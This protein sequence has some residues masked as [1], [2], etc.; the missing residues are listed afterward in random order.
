[1]GNRQNKGEIIIYKDDNTP[2]IKVNL[3]DNTVWLTQAQMA[4]LFDR[5]SDTIGEHIQNVYKTSE[6]SQNRTTGK[7]PVVQKE[8]NRE[9][10]REIEHYNLDMIISVGYR[11][12]SRR[13]TQFRI[14][15]TR[16]LRDFILKGYL[17]NEKRLQENQALK[18]KE[19][20][21]TISLFKNVL[22][23]K[24]LEGRE[25]DL[26]K[27]ITE[28]A[29]TWSLLNEYDKGNLKISDVTK[30]KNP[31]YLEYDKVKDSVT[32][33]KKRLAAS[34]DGSEIFGVETGNKLSQI[35]GSIRQT[36][37]GIDVYPSIEEKAAHLLYFTIKD[38]PFIDGNKR[39]GSLLFV[40]FMIE[41]RILMNRKG[42]RKINDAGLAALA[43]LV[44]ES[45]P[46]QKDVMVKLIVNLIN[47]K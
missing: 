23:S 40:L 28:Y 13:G 43:L 3:V 11:V 16:H 2:E 30:L 42:E 12:N 34:S 1:M 44:A 38:H 8:G 27:I 31:S 17:I 7:F 18:L 20:Q 45:K 29:D 47:K 35:L 41:N 37:D 25:A 6:L 46:S 33:F 14:W 10:K 22:E 19:I 36:F 5:N 26:L 15:A 9:V 21:Q 24:Q 4:L 32:R 39:I